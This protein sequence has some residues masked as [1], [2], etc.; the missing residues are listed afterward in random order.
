VPGDLTS[1]YLADLRHRLPAG[2]VD[3]IAGGLAEARE[4]HLA[5]GLTDL[6]A[7]HAAL[8]EFGDARQL[9]AQFTRHAPG[10]RTA[11]ILLTS[12][13]AV[14]SCW[15][16]ALIITR[17]WTWPVPAA[18]RIA[19]GAALLL[20]IAAL[21]SAATGQHSFRRTRLA[22]PGSIGLIILDTTMIAAALLSAPAF[23]WVLA[24]ATAASLTRLG[25][26][27]RLIPRTVTG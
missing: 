18:A 2:I 6:D 13:P 16:A 17:A 4:H 9:A 12:G 20:A 11:R 10:P 1:A 24:A 8:A 19:F 23:T 25:L 5:R 14:G 7:A 27:A 3:E 26:A 15:G 22:A 21:A